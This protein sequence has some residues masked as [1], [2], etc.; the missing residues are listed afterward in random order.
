MNRHIL[1]AS[2][3]KL[4]DMFSLNTEGEKMKETIP[5]QINTMDGEDLEVL[6]EEKRPAWQEMI[7]RCNKRCKKIPAFFERSL[8]DEKRYSKISCDCEICE[9]YAEKDDVDVTP[10]VEEWNKK[11]GEEFV[12][13]EVEETATTICVPSCWPAEVPI[14]QYARHIFAEAITILINKNHDYSTDTDPLA[15]LRAGANLLGIPTSEHILAIVASKTQRLVI[16]GRKGEFKVKD[17]SPKDNVRDIINYMA[18]YER[19]L[20]GEKSV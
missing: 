15:N 8:E 19:A 1:F 14:V 4:A 3:E 2:E 9:Y 6:M 20:E 16:I 18:L 17:E 13:T 12:P 10:L 5:G 7:K 11:M